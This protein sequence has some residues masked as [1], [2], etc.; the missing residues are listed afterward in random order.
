MMDD[1]S[2]TS[3]PHRLNENIIEV[4]RARNLSEA[5]MLVNVLADQGIEAQIGGASSSG[6]YAEVVGWHGSPQVLAFE[7]DRIRARAII[8]EYLNIILDENE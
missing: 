6:G 3:D 2:S 1:S 7:N 5:Q 4:Y 8:E